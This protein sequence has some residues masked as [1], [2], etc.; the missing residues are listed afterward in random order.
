LNGLETIYMAKVPKLKPAMNMNASQS[1]IKAR[2][3]SASRP[4][5]FNPFR[6][7]LDRF[8]DDP[9]ELNVNTMM[10]G[11]SIHGGRDILEIAD[12]LDRMQRDYLSHNRSGVA[13]QKLAHAPH[14]MMNEQQMLAESEGGYGVP[15][16]MLSGVQSHYVETKHP[17]LQMDARTN[18]GGKRLVANSEAND[19]MDGAKKDNWMPEM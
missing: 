12:R 10:S 13:T 8:A 2:H 1:T 7:T 19:S 5:D 18:S 16:G 14:N 15:N 4:S 17:G 3:M 9:A 6:P 11:G